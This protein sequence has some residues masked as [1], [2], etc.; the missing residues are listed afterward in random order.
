MNSYVKQQYVSD[1]FLE[2]Q[3][4]KLESTEETEDVKDR[5]EKSSY[6]TPE[7]RE[8]E[9]A[10]ILTDEMSRM[11]KILYH[12]WK[13]FLAMQESETITDN[14]SPAVVLHMKDLETQKTQS[15]LI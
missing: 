2:M 5:S 1:G 15:I 3:L 6:F 4:G 8:L 13:Y 14:G 11:G 7:N 12:S 9:G 10:G